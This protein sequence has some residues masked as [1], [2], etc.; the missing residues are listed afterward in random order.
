[1]GKSLKDQL[2]VLSAP[3][4]TARHSERAREHVTT[5]FDKFVKDIQNVDAE[6]PEFIRLLKTLQARD[7]FRTMKYDDRLIMLRR[8]RGIGDIELVEMY[9]SIHIQEGLKPC[10]P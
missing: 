2:S 8:L 3:K 5:T 9:R 4:P 6:S 7:L 1:M 10:R